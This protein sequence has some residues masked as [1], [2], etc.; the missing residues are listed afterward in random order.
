LIENGEAWIDMI[1]SRN[2]TSHTY[3]E[4]IAA[5]I[6]SAVRNSYFTEFETLRIN[7]KKLRRETD[8]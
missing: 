1:Q 3:D 8:R 4:A 6:A 2:L 7:L 5:S